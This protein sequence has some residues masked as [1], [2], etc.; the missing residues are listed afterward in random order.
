MIYDRGKGKMLEE[1]LPI[2]DHYFVQRRSLDEKQSTS[3][4]HCGGLIKN[5]PLA[6]GM[7]GVEGDLK[8]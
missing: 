4:E 8:A 1:E 6:R 2:L 3:R 5:L 7:F